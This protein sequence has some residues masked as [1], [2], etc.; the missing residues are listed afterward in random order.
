MQAI[1]HGLG[2][3]NTV[4][5][6]A[7][8]RLPLFDGCATRRLEKDWQAALPAHTLM[9]RA[10][11]AAARL[12]LALRPHAQRIWVACGPGNNGGDGLE[13]ALHLA[14]W[15]KAVHLTWLGT[16]ERTPPD[17]HRSW[18]QLEAW[19][20]ATGTTALQWAEAPPERFDLCIDALL[21]IGAQR[22]PEGRAAAWIGHINSGREAGAT[23]LSLDL[24]S[25][26]FAGSGVAHD[27]HVQATDTLSL[28]TLKPGLF[29]HQ[30]RDACGRIW[31]DDLGTDSQTPEGKGV[32]TAWLNPAPANTVQAHASHKGSRGDVVVVGGAPGMTGAAWLASMAALHHGAGRVHTVLLDAADAGAPA[33]H[34][35]QPELMTAELASQDLAR[36]RSAVVCGC[37]GGRAVQTVLTR[38][39]ADSARLVLDADALNAL[40]G[41]SRTA[42]AWRRQ[43]AQRHA[44]GRSTVLT[45]HPLEAARLLGTDTAHVQAHRMSSAQKLAETYR[46]TVVLKGSGTVIAAAGR[47]PHINP[48]GN[49]RLATAGTGDVLA[50]LIGAELAGGRPDFEAACRA[51][52]HHGHAAGPLDDDGPALTASVLARGG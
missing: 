1:P 17:S 52:Y 35:L 51:V 27:C 7:G 46:C 6:E 13:A 50:G 37:G 41:D 10:G 18:A 22:P 4:L 8:P 31:L 34:P 48:T 3:T 15:G 45:P 29:T 30:G 23:V 12:A 2:A 32:P 38:V 19:R 43:V 9:A 14:R 20:T 49:A 40:A 5:V 16:P 33:F 26:L 28:L 36:P 11:L 39:L 24:P 25:G 42:P 47:T 44:A 21:G